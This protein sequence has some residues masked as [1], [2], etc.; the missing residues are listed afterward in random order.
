MNKSSSHT[1]P[2]ITAP[3]AWLQDEALLQ[4]F[5]DAHLQ[6]DQ[7][8]TVQVVSDYLSFRLLDGGAAYYDRAIKPLFFT[9]AAQHGTAPTMANHILDSLTLKALTLTYGAGSQ[10]SFAFAPQ[11]SLL[12]LQRVMQESV[13][14]VV[15]SAAQQGIA[16]AALGYHPKYDAAE[17]TIVS[18]KFNALMVQRYRAIGGQGV[19]AM[20]N[21]AGTSIR[22]TSHSEAD[23]IEKWR[24]LMLC[25]PFLEA[26]FANSPIEK[27]ALQP[28]QSL[29]VLK[30][31]GADPVRSHL[32]EQLFEKDFSYRAFAEWALHRPLLGLLREGRGI[33][34]GYRTFAECVVDRSIYVAA[35]DWTNHLTSLHPPVR[36]SNG[37][38]EISVTD[39][40]SLTHTLAL[41]AWVKGLTHSSAIRTQILSKLTLM[42]RFGLLFQKAARDGLHAVT[43]LG[44]ALEVC[45]M[46][47]TWAEK[48]LQSSEDPEEKTLLA[49]IHAALAHNMSPADEWRLR[50]HA[51]DLATPHALLLAAQPLKATFKTPVWK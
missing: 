29:R 11:A 32:V 6:R 3:Q 42:P 19:D 8:Q 34:V 38:L 39:T 20:V 10:L 18:K 22:I 17:H 12:T 28:V 49:P 1:S 43:P 46:L 23:T 7:P 48:G 44:S 16:L 36:W 21:S 15:E 47:L 33:D 26:A 40:G 35:E 45:K 51:D 13:Q 25:A 9:L 4:P 24:V 37:S 27:G 41:A 14:Q 5:F 2:L 31:L 30:W 50:F